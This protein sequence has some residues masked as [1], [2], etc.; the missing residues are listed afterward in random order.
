MFRMGRKAVGLV[1]CVMHV[2]EPSYTYRKEKGFAP[3][4]LAV[5]AECVAAPCKSV[6]GV[7]YM[8][9]IIH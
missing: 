4:F 6:Q 2:K 8:S 3:V 9:L 1:C 5:A 7:T